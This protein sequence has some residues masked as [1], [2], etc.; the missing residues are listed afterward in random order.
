M[1]FPARA[2][3]EKYGKLPPPF[4]PKNSLRVNALGIEKN[5]DIMICLHTESVAQLQTICTSRISLMTIMLS[6]S[7]SFFFISP[8]L[9]YFIRLSTFRLQPS[10]SSAS[11]PSLSTLP[12]LIVP[13]LLSFSPLPPYLPANPPSHTIFSISR[14]IIVVVVVQGNEASNVTG[15]EGNPVE[16]SKYAALRR[17]FYRRPRKGNS[18]QRNLAHL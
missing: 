13:H 12:P 7:S 9:L 11:T 10:P 1:A 4:Q 6:L 5:E 15:P 8:S 2:P 14:G 16:G 3:S 18:W 17:R